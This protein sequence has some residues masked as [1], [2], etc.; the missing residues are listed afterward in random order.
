MGRIRVSH[1]VRVDGSQD[2]FR[3]I[4]RLRDG[5]TDISYG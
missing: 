5:A 4:L 3:P 2:Q 1:Y